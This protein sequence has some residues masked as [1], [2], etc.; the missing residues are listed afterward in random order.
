MSNLI[1]WSNL[2]P[3]FCWI[4]IYICILLVF[5]IIGHII[6]SWRIGIV[7]GLGMVNGISV[8]FAT[9]ATASQPAWISLVIS[10]MSI[11][12]LFL[13][14]QKVHLPKCKQNDVSH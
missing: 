14:S 6:G 1:I 12:V 4:I 5:Q 2:H 13:I 11:V 10:F 9:F 7:I 8:A 3:I